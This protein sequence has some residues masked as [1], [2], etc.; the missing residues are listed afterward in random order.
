VV[1]L[2]LSIDALEAAVA[3]LSGAGSGDED[4]VLS[5]LFA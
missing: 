5:V 4:D 2:T 1:T 3:G